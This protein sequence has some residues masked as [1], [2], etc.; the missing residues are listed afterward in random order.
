MAAYY[1]GVVK[2]LIHELKYERAQAAATVLADLLVS[3]LDISQFDLITAIPADPS[4]R[5][6]R[7]YNQAELVAKAVARKLDFPYVETLLRVK[8]IHQIGAE[9]SRRLQQVKG[10]FLPYRELFIKDARILVI[11][12]VVTTGATLAEAAAVL[13]QS[14]AKRIWGAAIAKH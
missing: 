5:R 12:D 14:G 6:Q 11:D 13:K 4:R 3:H 8:S 9:R 10:A 2:D 1:D 7:G